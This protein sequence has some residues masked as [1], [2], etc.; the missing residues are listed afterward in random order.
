MS[1]YDVYKQCDMIGHMIE[2]NNNTKV[3]QTSCK[4]FG[5]LKNVF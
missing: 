1:W 3:A 5:V 4:F 2:K